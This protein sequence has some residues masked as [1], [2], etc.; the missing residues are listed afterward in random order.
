MAASEKQIFPALTGLRAV[1]AYLVF[2][3][4]TLPQAPPGGNILDILSQEGHMGVSVF[5]VLSGFLIGLRYSSSFENNLTDYK[6]FALHRL[7]RLYPAYLLCTLFF[8]IYKREGV[9]AWVTNLFMVQGLFDDLHYTG[10]GIGWSLTVEVCFYAAAP[11]VLLFWNRIGLLGWTLLTLLAG[12]ALVAAGELPVPYRF[13]VGVDFMIRGT[14]F[15]RCLEFYLGIWVARHFFLNST[16]SF[17]QLKHGLCT[18]FGLA[19]TISIMLLLAF[20]RGDTPRSLTPE[21]L[22]WFN[23]I[24]NLALP[25]FLALLILGLALEK[26]YLQRLLGSRLVQELGKGSYFFYLIHFKVGA[27]FL[28]GLLWQNRLLIWFLMVVASMA[29][30]YLLE[31]P[32]QKWL[33]QKLSLKP[34][35]KTNQANLGS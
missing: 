24:N 34:E 5:F 11:L 3:H 6:E 8:S 28:F 1:A 16:R 4:H 29:G 23:G 33:L 17:Y 21:Q 13:M 20:V 25:P 31:A 15:G 10:I 22:N 7:A 19:G 2:A 26:T 18:Y 14:F 35:I 30:Y 12:V 9:A 27:S 32:V